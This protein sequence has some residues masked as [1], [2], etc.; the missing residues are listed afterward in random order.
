MSMFDLWWLPKHPDFR[1]AWKTFQ[2]QMEK[3]ASNIDAL[4]SLVGYD[5]DFTQLIHIDR[6]LGQMLSGHE[7]VPGY[8]RVKMAFLSSST[9]DHLIPFLRTAALRRRMILD[10]YC[11][12]FNLYKQEILNADSPLYAFK[13][14]VIW[15][16]LDW[17]NAG[18]SIPLTSSADDASRHVSS[19]IDEF[20][21][22]W[23]IV[24]TR[25]QATVVQE[26]VVIP[27]ISIFGH[28]DNQIA[29][30]PHQLLTQLNAG[31]G[32]AV[33]E[34]G[35]LLMDHD[36]LAG[37]VGKKEWLQ[38]SLWHHAKQVVAPT[39]GPLYGDHVAR[40]LAAL[41]GHSYK[42]LVLDLDNTLWGGVIGD[43]G[44]GGLELGMGGAVGEAFQ[45]FQRYVKKLNERGIILAACSKNNEQTALSPFEKHPEMILK[46]DDFSVFVANWNDKAT[47]IAQIAEILNIGRDAIV[48]FDDNPVER[49][50]V[51]DRCPDV[52]VHETPEDPALFIASL[53]EAGYFEA[54]SFSRDDVQRTAQYQANA[55]RATLQS[56]SANL[57]DFLKSL[58]MQM[59]IAPFDSIERARI[60]QLIN[61]SNQFN[62]TT[63]RYT[64]AQIQDMGNDPRILTFQVRLKDRFG[65]NGLISVLIAKPGVKADSLLIDTWLM[66]C[67]VLGREVEIELLNA[68]V[69]EALVR[70][71]KFVFGEYI[72]TEK[73]LLVKDHFQKLGFQI[74][75][76]MPAGVKNTYWKLSLADFNNSPTS[77]KVISN[78]EKRTL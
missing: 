71:Y 58:E 77:I 48:F 7:D 35:G 59:H 39:C 20:K 34:H 24:R 46:R 40:I 10:I 68:L 43:D 3:R 78:H 69:A 53:S 61:K 31:L 54:T 8:A 49:Q 27:P 70:G 64:E 15:F 18:V 45:E 41:R 28:M 55:N 1:S 42:A 6:A 72:P 65:D 2:L 67:R 36:S 14:V 44:L 21:N 13:P 37:Q 30:T 33:K 32:R 57:H 76:E 5:L 9:V 74:A 22:L 63:R 4:R 16:A 23:S 12:P 62:L 66:S 60:A 29:S 38:P 11:P 50:L 52:A 51:R 17:Q 47:N 25:L 73:N 26:T 56:E 19:I 75:S